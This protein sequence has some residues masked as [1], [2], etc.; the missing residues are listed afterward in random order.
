[1]VVDFDPVL[2]SIGPISIRWY[3]LMY[4]IG[5]VLGTYLLKV[6]SERKFLKLSVEQVDQYVFQLFVGML[7][8]ARLVYVFVYN[9]EEYSQGQWWE[10]I[11]IW[12]GGLSFHGAVLGMSIATYLFARRHGLHFFHL[13]DAMAIAGSPGLFFGRMGNF[14]NGELYGR[15]TESWVGMIF[16]AGGPYPRHP[17]QLYE[18]ILEGLVLFIILWWAKDKVNR[19]GVISAIFM[20]GYGS[21][22]FIVEFFR[23]PDPQLGLYFNLVSMGQ[24]LCSFMWAVALLF[25][26]WSRQANLRLSY[27]RG[28]EAQ[29]QS[30]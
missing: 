13:A 27:N 19:Y 3:G 24:I 7:I 14:I 17:S 8:G 1:M 21:A 6:L 30:H 11:A 12:Q 9:F 4:I 18:G 5:F 28:S 26:L 16:P 22:R 15:V 23:Q 2:F 29:S 10:F 20:L 25:Y